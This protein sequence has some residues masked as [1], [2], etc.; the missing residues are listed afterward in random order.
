MD[1]AVCRQWLLS[2]LAAA[3]TTKEGVI[4]GRSAE[5]DSLSRTCSCGRHTGIRALELIDI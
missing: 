2:S 4:G 1:Y 3:H 5:R